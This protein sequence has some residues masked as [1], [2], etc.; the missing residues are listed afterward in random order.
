MSKIV[1]SMLLSVA[2]TAG[3]SELISFETGY[4]IVKD[5]ILVRLD[6]ANRKMSVNFR[7]PAHLFD[8]VEYA[9][10]K[11]PEW[12]AKRSQMDLFNQE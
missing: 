4:D 11:W 3:H 8:P 6:A 5:D 7:I 9:I 12:F 2:V 10:A 1:G